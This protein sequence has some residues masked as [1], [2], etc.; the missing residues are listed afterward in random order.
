MV[1]K[2]CGKKIPKE[3]L[4]NYYSWCSRKCRNVWISKHQKWW[5]KN[6]KRYIESR[7]PA[8]YFGLTSSAC[9]KGSD[10]T[11]V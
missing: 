9:D 8:N 5:K 6:K 3:L 11:N 10:I 2:V 4:N 7:H 1:C